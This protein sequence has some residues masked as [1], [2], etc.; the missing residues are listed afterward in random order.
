MQALYAAKDQPRIDEQIFAIHPF[1]PFW[2]TGEP[3]QIEKMSKLQPLVDLIEA[4]T[5][6][7]EDIEQLLTVLKK[8]GHPTVEMDCPGQ[9]CKCDFS[10]N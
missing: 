4:G 1:L 5:L 10:H 6:D 2:G 9:H 7:V 3:R 8:K